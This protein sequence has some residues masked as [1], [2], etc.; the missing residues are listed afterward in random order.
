MCTRGFMDPANLLQKDKHGKPWWLGPDILPEEHQANNIV[1]DKM[2]EGN[3]EIKKKDILV[4]A[5]F[6]KQL[7]LEYQ[8][9]IRVIC[10]MKW[11]CWNQR[12]ANKRKRFLTCLRNLRSWRITFE[13]DSAWRIWNRASSTDNKPTIIKEKQAP[14]INTI[15]RR[16]RYNKNWRKIIK[17]RHPEFSKT[18]I[19]TSWQT[20][21][22][23]TA[24]STISWNLSLWCRICVICNRA[25]ILGYQG[26]WERMYGMQTK[27]SKT[28]SIFHEHLTFVRCIMQVWAG[29][30]FF[31][32]IH[33]KLKR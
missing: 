3:A 10:W 7:C 31:G 20:S 25:K 27:K 28:K 16:I 5:T 18:S 17:S 14:Q 32:L 9:I 23:E 21:C 6:N 4:T 22:S 2:D 30:Y 19:N 1:I 29:N 11:F 24:Y 15:S 26:D 33:V 13:M 12:N 8:K